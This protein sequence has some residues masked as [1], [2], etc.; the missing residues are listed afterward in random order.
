MQHILQDCELGPSVTK[1]DLYVSNQEALDWLEQSRR[2]AT[3]PPIPQISYASTSAEL[4]DKSRFDYFSRVVPPDTYQ[5]QAMVDLAKELGWTYV[6]TVASEGNYGENGV[7]TF[8]ARARQNGV[9]IAASEKIDRHASDE[10]F[11]DIIEYL[12]KTPKAR[13]V[14]VFADEDDLKKLIAAAK[15]KIA[16]PRP[17]C[18]RPA[19]SAEANNQSE[20]P[21]SVT[22]AIIP[23]V[24]PRRHCCAVT[25]RFYRNQTPLLN[26]LASTDI[27]CGWA[28]TAGAQRSRRWRAKKRPPRGPS[29]FSSRAKRSQKDY[30][31]FSPEC[32]EL[33]I[34]RYNSGR[35]DSTSMIF[36]RHIT[37]V[38]AEVK[39]KFRLCG[40]VRASQFDSYFTKLK[41]ENN[42]R[43]VWFEEYWESHFHCRFNISSDS[44]TS[45]S[46][47]RCTGE[48]TVSTDSGYVQ[49]GKVQFVVDSVYA[50][51]HALHDMRNDLCP[52]TTS[53]LCEE[54][55]HWNNVHGEQF[56]EYIRNVTFRGIG[57]DTVAFNALGDGPGRYDIYQYQNKNGVYQYVPIGTWDDSRARR[58]S[59]RP[60]LLHW[61]GNQTM[62]SPTSIC[63]SE[64]APGERK[65]QQASAC[66]WVCQR[67]E[68]ATQR[69][70]DESTCEDCPEGQK[71]GANWTTCEDIRIKSVSWT[72]LYSSIP[73]VFSVLGILVV[74]TVVGI[75]KVYS[76]TP[77]VRASGRELS[78]VLLA[79]I[80]LCYCMTFILL[81][82]PS[83]V[84][85]CVTRVFLGLGLAMCYSA[86]LI[87]TN[88]IY[89]IFEDG[90]KSAK[91][92][93]WISPKSQL[94]FC[95]LFVSIQLF[96]VVVWLV[97]DPPDTYVEYTAIE[98]PDAVG[99]RRCNV[100]D[101]S[102]VI[103]LAYNMLLVVLC[104]VYAFM[105][106]NI[107]SSYNESKYIA[108]SMYTTCIVWLAFIPIFFGTAH[109]PEKMQIQ[110]TTLTVS[111]S[112]SGTVSLACL[113]A[114]KVYIILF[115]PHKNVR[116]SSATKA[117]M[118]AK[119]W[120]QVARKR[121]EQRSSVSVVMRNGDLEVS[122]PEQPDM[123][124]QKIPSSDT[125]V[126]TSD[127]KPV[128]RFGALVDRTTEV[129]ESGVLTT[130]VS[131]D[132]PV[133]GYA[134]VKNL[135]GN[136][137]AESG[138][139][140]LLQPRRKPGQNHDRH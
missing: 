54:M 56:L 133:G 75:Y 84:T 135:L 124:I 83:P 106:R 125:I 93:K 100:S 110:V 67:C 127:G 45:T 65:I 96:A 61:P 22:R 17:S 68:R 120:Q 103:S 55:E 90:K 49:E 104:T 29:Q 15:R 119:R 25:Q 98:S 99:V 132:S 64:C 52:G 36:G 81:S 80:F 41:P 51:A 137:L 76:D 92:V 31:I 30:E 48:E 11:E 116:A 4:S 35:H 21:F 27:S 13:A 37:A 26:D 7:E 20:T 112:M 126:S 78:Y 118:V 102:L 9:C 33:R 72:S 86:L 12:G 19:I 50:M 47:R 34:L 63:S 128:Y 85:C 46:L 57:G 108:F 114:P 69:L 140:K 16:S 23:A 115:Q 74:A 40:G 105:T 87:K 113:F 3:R 117:A 53:G 134:F 73:I 111:I 121:S 71:P 32:G 6:S 18:C 91:A 44:G 82:P 95:A 107:P 39:Y 42:R 60:S 14:I 58:L 122:S 79:G 1:R 62:T 138:G 130:N 97:V 2:S 89:R 129:A 8:A 70:R 131:T 43:D 24:I 38:E 139:E 28:V 88:R 101:T 109:S 123:D 94:I 66:C 10:T 5:A 136:L 77:V 59:L